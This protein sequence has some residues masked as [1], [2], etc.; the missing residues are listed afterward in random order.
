MEPL[1]SLVHISGPK[2]PGPGERKQMLDRAAEVFA[3]AGV[4]PSDI[5]R[6]HVPGRGQSESGDATIRPEVE[7]VVPALQ[8]GSL[9]GGR[10][11]VMVLD[12]HQL[13][14]SEAHAVADLL[15]PPEAA[16]RQVVFVSSGRLPAA[17]G[18][19]IKKN[20]ESVS[21][22]KL[23]ERDALDWTRRAA[24]KRRL[25][26]PAE[27]A[28][29]LVERFGSDIEALSQ[30][31]DQL[32]M[33]E[34]PVTGEM[35][36]ARFRNRPEEPIWHF[37][38]ALADGRVDEALRRLHDLLTHI[39][40]LFLLAAIENDLRRRSFASAAPDMET[41]A[42]WIGTKPDSYP[43]RKGWHAGRSMSVDNLKRALEAV[44]RTDATLKT[45]P[46]ETHLVTMERLAVSLCYWYGR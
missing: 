35:V 36:R 11:G 30:A 15:A 16:S 14:A 8:S 26:L 2:E 38:D 4:E 9:F 22:R 13:S 6:I 42:N 41:Y 43:A 28:K 27:A 18:A 23:R 45:M 39:H 20:G 17:L 25:R 24:R 33:S 31:L 19:Y 34:D 32:K 46:E 5:V 3:S 10:T 7:P 44:R 21:I 1:K 12:A 29:A 37:T 40:P